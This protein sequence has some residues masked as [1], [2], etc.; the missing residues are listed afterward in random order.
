[1]CRLAGLACLV[2]LAGLAGWSG[3]SGRASWLVLAG[4]A[5]WAGLAGS[6][7]FGWLRLIG[8]GHHLSWSAGLEW[9]AGWPVGDHGFLTGQTFC[10]EGPTAISL[11]WH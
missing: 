7:R 9:L 2:G 10:M 1:M 5:D 3:W 4:W 11:D 6:A 8:P